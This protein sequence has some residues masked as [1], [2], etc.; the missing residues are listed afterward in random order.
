MTVKPSGL[1]EATGGDST[2]KELGVAFGVSVLGSIFLALMFGRVV[3]G[4]FAFH[5]QSDV[6]KAEH[7]QAVIE[8]GNWAAKITDDQWGEGSS[9]VC[10][11]RPVL[12]TRRSWPMLTCPLIGTPWRSSSASS[13]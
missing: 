12:R 11:R 8:L 10:R 13:W 2:G 4:Y 7:A 9:T 3:D 1:G 5:G 6:T